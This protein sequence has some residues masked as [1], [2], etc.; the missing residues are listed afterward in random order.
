MGLLVN[1]NNNIKK[2]TKIMNDKYDFFKATENLSTKVDIITWSCR[3]QNVGR[4]QPL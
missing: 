2:K 1:S 3:K 4:I